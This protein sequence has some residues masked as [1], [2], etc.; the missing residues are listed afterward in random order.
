MSTIWLVIAMLVLLHTVWTIAHALTNNGQLTEGKI[1]P[2][3]SLPYVWGGVSIIA[4]GQILFVLI[5]K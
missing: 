1:T 5:L 3:T 2:H 4:L